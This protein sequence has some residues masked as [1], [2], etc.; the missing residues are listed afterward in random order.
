MRNIFLF[1]IILFFCSSCQKEENSVL[2][3]WYKAPGNNWNE[4]L[5]IGNGHLGA[6]IYGKIDK[7]VIQLNDNT[8]YSGEPD[9]SWKEVDIAPSYDKVVSM[10]YSGKYREAT[11]FVQQNWLGRQ[12]QAYQPLGNWHIDNHVEGKIT[13]YRR[14]LDLSSSI[15]RITYK[16]NNIN[17]IR[18]IFASHPDD[19]IVM[20]LGCDKNNGLDVTVSLSSV[21]STAKQR[22]SADGIIAMSGQAPGY[23][24]RRSLDQIEKWG[25][26]YK[27][28]ELF[29]SD[30]SRKYDK[31]V[32]YGEEIDG[33]GTFFETRIKAIAPSAIMSVNERG[34]RISGTN[35][36]LLILSSATSFNGF[37]KSPS[38]EG[39]DAAHVVDSILVETAGCTYND[40]KKRHIADYHSLFNRVTFEMPV[41]TEQNSLP[42]DQRIIRYQNNSDNGLIALLFHYGRYLMISGSRPQGQPLN[43]QGIWNDRIIP[44]WNGGYTCNINAEMNYWPAELTN[45]SECHQPFLQMA[46]EIAISGSVTAQNMYHCRGWMGHHNASIWRET[47]PNDGSPVSAYWPMMGAWLCSHLWEHYLFT[48]DE[49]F[50][51]EEAYPLMKGA[52][53]FFLDWLVDNGSGYWVTPVSTSPENMFLTA[54]GEQAAVSMGSTMDMSMIRELLT[55]TQSAAEKLRVD[56]SLRKEIQDKLQRL[57][58]YQIGARGQ[59]QEWQQ[60]FDESAP[61]HRHLSHLYGLYPGNQINFDQTPEIMQA[62]AKTLDTRGDEATGWSM[63]WKINLWARMLD[64]NRANSI[65]HNLF[66]PVGFGAIEHLGGGLY[67]NMFDAHP[68]FQIDGNFGFTAGIVEMLLQSHA[69]V[70]H[71]LPALPSEWSEGKITGLKARGGFIVDVEWR[72]GKLVKACITSTLGGNCRLRTNEKIMLT[73]PSFEV[74]GKNPN[75]FYDTIDPGKPLGI[76][77]LGANEFPVK[78]CY[79]VDFMTKKGESYEVIPIIN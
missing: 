67:M 18:E 49:I 74:K 19:V 10:L 50:L 28:P 22:V 33:K 59:L 53:E 12:H 52:S 13:G 36:I 20:R 35:E 11:D 14:E 41:T 29:N 48:G 40:L 30:G 23:V 4:A 8:L 31:K 32:L 71:L 54:N 56:E 38:R 43:L 21:H 16:Q 77:N 73:V 9:V 61:Q 70:L 25:D 34:L 46:K 51:K 44:P 66:R 39:R 65:I 55:R 1:L 2:C 45:L 27:Y 3:L 62:V 64:G 75:Y 78:S 7:E 26:Q 47:Y 42:T 69:G 58:P 57:L 5:P 76:G 63:G 60:D 79:T 72:E 68:P 15:Q 17:Y 6:M 37:Y 24:E